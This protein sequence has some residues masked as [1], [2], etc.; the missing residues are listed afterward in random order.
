MREEWGKS[1]Q[2][3]I[4][5]ESRTDGIKTN[6]LCCEVCSPRE[7]FPS[8]PQLLTAPA[9]AAAPPLP[10][11]EDFQVPGSCSHSTEM[12]EVTAQAR[13]GSVCKCLF[14]LSKRR[15]RTDWLCRATGYFMLKPVEKIWNANFHQHLQQVPRAVP[16]KLQL[17]HCSSKGTDP[18]T[19]ASFSHS[20]N[21]HFLKALIKRLFTEPEGSPPRSSQLVAF[22][23][24]DQVEL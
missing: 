19:K 4:S 16:F 2:G 10:S 5:T 8:G 11:P 1:N 14:F 7:P 12:L 21:K 6:L 24:G 9:G 13:D 18:R 15:Q 17:L 20:V 22:Q 3:D 23:L